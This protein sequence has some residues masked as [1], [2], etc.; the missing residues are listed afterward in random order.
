MKKLFIITAIGFIITTFSCKK[1]YNGSSKNPG[2]IQHK[3][4]V[5]S[6]NGE[7]LRYV[8]TPDDYYNFST[9]GN[10]YQHVSNINDTLAYV[11]LSDGSTISFYQITDG[12]KSSTPSN[13]TI[14]SLTSSQFIISHF[15]G[16]VYSLDSLK[17]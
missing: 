1:N 3:W 17:R 16:I 4:E 8:G 5:V 7:A 14:K 10:L 11:L 6:V 12:V 9:D 2:L 13:Y 15:S